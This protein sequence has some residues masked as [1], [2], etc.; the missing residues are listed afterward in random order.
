MEELYN[1]INF[2]VSGGALTLLTDF[3]GGK[4]LPALILEESKKNDGSFMVMDAAGMA[5]ESLVFNEL[6]L[7]SLFSN[8]PI[9]GAFEVS[10]AKG[11]DKWPFIIRVKGAHREIYI[12][13]GK[14]PAEPENFINELQPYAG[15]INLWQTFQNIDDTEKKLSRLSYMLLA[16]KS[17]LASVFEPMP[18][19]YFAAFLSDV[20]RES[21][22]PENIVVLKDEGNYLTVFTEGSGG[23]KIPERKGI[24]AEHILPPVPVVTNG[25][26]TPF[27]VVLP[28]T[29]GSCRL[30]C[31]MHWNYLPDEQMM[32]FLELLGN[33]AVRAIAINNL[34]SQ[35]N[36]SASYISSGEFTVLSLSNVLKI[37]KSAKDKSRFLSM[38]GDIFTEQCRMSD[39]ILAVWDE[40]RRGY[41]IAEKR[42]GQIKTDLNPALLPA[43]NPVEANNISEIFYDLKADKP[44]KIFKSWGLAGC[45]WEEMGKMRYL[46]PISDDN[47]LVGMIAL[48]SNNA[49]DIS[50]LDKAQIASLHLIA[51]FAGYEFK[52]F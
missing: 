27:E 50:Q 22:F 13:L 33:L 32:N 52:R 39:C 26:K 40:K 48:A 38:L 34:R 23:A 29:E 1:R 17:T 47:L 42:V 4:K 28:V 20:L 5:P 31:V 2:I 25:T 43:N 19:Q 36:Q 8:R 15:L 21:L 41:V 7:K 12:L 9:L 35:T 10:S 24:Y 14:E 37:L 30:F 3:L 49:G 6:N 18:L 11:S 45:P 16:T 46:F 51:Q 44:D